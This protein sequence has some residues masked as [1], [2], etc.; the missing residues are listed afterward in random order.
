[1]MHRCLRSVVFAV[2]AVV[3][4]TACG[5]SRNDSSSESVAGVT[6]ASATD[7]S[8]SAVVAQTPPAADETVAGAPAE[9]S[10]AAPAAAPIRAVATFYPISWMV[11]RI[12]GE[13]VSVTNLTPPGVEPH[14]LELAPD[15][16]DALTDADVAIVMGR[17]FQPG[18]EKIAKNRKKPTVMFLNAVSAGD[19]LV[20]E[21]EEGDIGNDHR[22]S[23]DPHVWLDP[24]MFSTARGEIVRTL[25]NVDPGGAAD[26]SRRSEELGIALAELDASMEAGLKTCKRRTMVTAHE[27]FGR[28]AVRYGLTQEGI[29]GLSPDA[30]PD[31]Q[32]IAD[33][34]D[35][36]KKQGLTTVFFEEL[37]P[38]NFADTLAREAGVRTAMLSPLEAPTP[39]EI[40]GGASYLTIMRTNLETLRTALDCK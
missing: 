26:Y 33:L 25:S 27:A 7:T 21:H 17:D 28:L 3:S 18:P 29:A 40:A 20:E 2:A 30:E 4:L 15:Q 24:R 32:R 36:V 16:V 1:M 10:A 38:Q 13:R 5:S 23:L 19:G 22:K 34:T 8:V 35:L 37:A 12:G 39:D 11:E 9:T 14:D 31:P 6:D